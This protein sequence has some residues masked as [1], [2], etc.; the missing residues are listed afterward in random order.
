MYTHNLTRPHTHTHARTHTVHIC[1]WS[2]QC[3]SSLFEYMGRVAPPSS[4]SFSLLFSVFPSSF[5]YLLSSPFSFLYLLPLS[6][7]FSLSFPPSSF[8]YILPHSIL[9]LLYL[10]SSLYLLISL[11]YLPPP[12][13][14]LLFSYLSSSH[15]L[16]Q[17]HNHHQI[18]HRYIQYA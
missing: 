18:C 8:L 1:R 16:Y 17:V 3:H 2:R 15:I 13:S 5:L 4:T 6:P 14:P 10:L 12:L 7:S 11:F 9:F